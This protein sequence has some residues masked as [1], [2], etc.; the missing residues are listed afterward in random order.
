MS[1][2][3]DIASTATRVVCVYNL[4]PRLPRI[5]HGEPIGSILGVGT[6][7]R[8]VDQAADLLPRIVSISRISPETFCG[9]FGPLF[10]EVVLI[11]FQTVRGDPLV[12]IDATVV[13]STAT[14][15]LRDYMDFMDVSR[16]HVTVGTQRITE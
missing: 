12:M 8:F 11:V 15:R 5:R 13:P 2:E 1:G 16:D 4:T 10:A 9:Q 6:R 14:A 3:G 7:Q